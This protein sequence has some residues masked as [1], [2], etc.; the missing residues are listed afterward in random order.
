MLPVEVYHKSVLSLNSFSC[1]LRRFNGE[2]GHSQLKSSVPFDDQIEWKG[3]NV[4]L[5]F[6][7]SYILRS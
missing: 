3:N 6:V 5:L 2:L 4:L 1:I 7:F